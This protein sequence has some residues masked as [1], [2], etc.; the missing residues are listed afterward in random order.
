MAELK[1][2]VFSLGTELY[3]LPIEKVERILPEM[4]VTKLPRTPKMFLGVFDLRGDTIPVLDARARFE[5]KS[6][7]ESGTFIVIMTEAGRCS[8]RVDRVDGIRS[9]DEVDIQEEMGVTGGQLDDFLVGVARDGQDLIVVLEPEA[10]LPSSM[11][12][13]MEKMA[14]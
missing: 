4:G 1:F 8:L 10:I 12:T 7:E 13:K 11:R 2:V 3:G 6:H 9:I 14:A 5:M